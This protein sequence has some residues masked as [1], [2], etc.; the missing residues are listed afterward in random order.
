[1]TL[2]I[3]RGKFTKTDAKVAYPANKGMASIAQQ[4]INHVVGQANAKHAEALK[5]EGMELLIWLRQ[6]SGSYCTCQQLGAS[7]HEHDLPVDLEA[8]DPTVETPVFE[9]K[10]YGVLNSSPTE[11]NFLSNN[12]LSTLSKKLTP[13]N[14]DAVNYASDEQLDSLLQGI[15][16]N[17]FVSPNEA[18]LMRQPE[19]GF[20][21]GD[22][23]RCGICFGTGFISGYQL[24]NGQR[25]ILDASAS[26][27]ISLHGSE[28]DSAVY[29]NRFTAP[30]QDDVYVSWEIEIPTFFSR[31]LSVHVRNNTSIA[32]GAIIEARV[33]NSAMP[34][35]P[36]TVE[37]LNSRKG[38]PTVLQVRVKPQIGSATAPMLE[39]THV[40]FVLQLAEF[41]YGQ[42]PDLS[43]SINM[44]LFD[45][46][47]SQNFEIGANVIGLDR[48]CVFVENKYGYAWKISDCTRKFTQA[49]QTFNW[50]G[51]ARVVQ[52]YEPLY[53]L[54]LARKQYLEL[55]FKKL[56]ALQGLGG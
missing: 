34:W 14:K 20:N 50:E 6:R 32:P 26:Q 27:R 43:K 12:K 22:K 48:E 45:V 30:R 35:T 36:F 28:L 42:M 23:T 55:N 37:F 24:F 25:F 44:D 8:N 41:P 7:P 49:G 46:L 53:L 15:D 56:E 19:G 33:L 39:F 38:Q 10:S 31:A 3:G 52:N 47:A 5:V 9:V 13:T 2:N 21:G 11:T 17:E 40:E 29:P 1:M 4:R 18:A 54:N 16:L 51:T